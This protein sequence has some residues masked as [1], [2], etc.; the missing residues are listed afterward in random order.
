[1]ALER[2]QGGHTRRTDC[3]W[4]A[5]AVEAS[6][7]GSA[8]VDA[9]A[10]GTMGVFGMI[11]AA[12]AAFVK[13]AEE[14]LDVAGIAGFGPAP[15]TVSNSAN[16]SD[17]GGPE[18][19]RPLCRR[20]REYLQSQQASALPNLPSYFDFGHPCLVVASLI[21]IAAVVVVVAAAVDNR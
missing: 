13:P 7:A 10:S 5:A 3:R 12:V 16:D 19:Q 1:M 21:A 8:V 4:I 14:T 20:S 15:G 9:A 6:V 11:A 2:A 18:P 17:S